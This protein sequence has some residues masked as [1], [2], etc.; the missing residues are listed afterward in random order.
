MPLTTASGRFS[1]NYFRLQR[2]TTAA[3]MTSPTLEGSFRRRR[4][5][6]N[7]TADGH[8]LNLLLTCSAGAATDVGTP[9]TAEW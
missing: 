7:A 3:A 2:T 1:R 6:F 5:R 8:R 9:T 4:R